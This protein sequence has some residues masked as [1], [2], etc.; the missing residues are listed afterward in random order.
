LQHFKRLI[1]FIRLAGEI[2]IAYLY[3]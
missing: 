3:L 2:N 1:T